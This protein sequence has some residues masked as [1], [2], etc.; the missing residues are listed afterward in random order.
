MKYSLLI[1]FNFQFL[2][3]PAQVFSNNN[4]AIPVPK[5]KIEVDQNY[6]GSTTLVWREIKM[7]EHNLIPNLANRLIME[8][9]EGLQAFHNPKDTIRQTQMT[10][11]N[12]VIFAE[13]YPDTTDRILIL[14]EWDYDKG[15]GKMAVNIL[16]IAPAYIG[17]GKYYPL[18]WN[19]YSHVTSILKN[20]EVPVDHNQTSTMY[21]VFDKRFFTSY[22]IK[23]RNEIN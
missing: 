3:C 16:A 7:Q 14:E 2:T 11:L 5:K 13:L 9:K 6:N 8:T 15:K 10:T 12:Q 20:M 18:F 23:Y 17:N 22:I 4:N 19:K 21:D 1:I